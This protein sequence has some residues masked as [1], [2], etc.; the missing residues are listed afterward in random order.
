MEVKGKGN[1]NK[2]RE[3]RRPKVAT[4]CRGFLT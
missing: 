2:V 4:H 3:K 1:E